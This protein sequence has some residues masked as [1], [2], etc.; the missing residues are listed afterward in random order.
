MQNF[1]TLWNYTY[2]LEI[3]RTSLYIRCR[4]ILEIGLVDGSMMFETLTYGIER[5]PRLD[6]IF[7]NSEAAVRAAWRDTHPNDTRI[8]ESHTKKD[9]PRLMQR[10][11]QKQS[12]Y[13]Y[14]HIYS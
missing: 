7:S 10:P 1:Y 14:I 6:S 12:I 9:A 3:C 4:E 13:T 11:T 2:G 5:S 8:H